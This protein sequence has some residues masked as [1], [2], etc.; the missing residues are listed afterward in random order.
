MAREQFNLTGKIAVVAGASRGIGQEVAKILGE[1]GA[2]V[3]CLSR[4]ADGCAETVAAIEALGGT[5]EMRACHIGRVEQIDE[6]YKYMDERHGRVD[7]LIN[8]AAANPYYG[9][10]LDTDVASFDKTVEVNLRGYFFM[11]IGAGRRMRAQGGGAIVN[12]ASANALSPGDKQG[13]YS[14]TKAG[15]HNMS[16]A[17]ARECGQFGIRVNTLVPGLTRTKF[18]MALHDDEEFMAKQ[19]PH[20]PLARGADPS[21]MAG[22]VLYLVS[23]AASY[24]TGSSIVIDGGYLA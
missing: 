10:I 4:G 8:N 15:I 17:L 2:H 19:M 22:A 20:T 3:V 14:M 24:T 16:K 1:Y 23:D 5:A 11:A 18:A 7:I 13:V 6:F 12:V 21:E 9:H